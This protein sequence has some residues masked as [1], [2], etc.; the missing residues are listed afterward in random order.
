VGVGSRG[1]R[2]GVLPVHLHAELVADQVDQPVDP[3]TLRGVVHVED[4]REDA[5]QHQ[6]VRDGD[7]HAGHLGGAL[8][9]VLDL[10]DGE[11][12]VRE[13]RDEQPVRQLARPIVEERSHDAG[14]ELRHRQ[15]DR[16]RRH[17]QHQGD[18]RHHRRRD[19]V[20]H[21]PRRHRVAGQ[22]LRDEPGMAAVDRDRDGRQQDA[23]QQ[24]EQRD[25]PQAVPQAVHHAL[26]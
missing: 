11:Q 10:A 6:D 18:Q 21:H 8:V 24:T 5:G 23:G 15:L 1:L 9:G 19:R 20:Q 25:Q 3:Q 17:G 26:G 14:R 4:Q 12:R 16:H 13:R 22:R 7:G 2:R